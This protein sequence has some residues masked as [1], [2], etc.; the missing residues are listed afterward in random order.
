MKK[1]N[2]LDK[3]YNPKLDIYIKQAYKSLKKTELKTNS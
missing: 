2:K 3:I 1:I